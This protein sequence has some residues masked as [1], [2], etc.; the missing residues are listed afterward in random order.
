MPEL[1]RAGP[2]PGGAVTTTGAGRSPVPPAPVP[3]SLWQ[4]ATP[5]LTV[6]AGT[7]CG[8]PDRRHRFGR[9][10]GGL[11]GV[12]R[13]L[14][15]QRP[16]S[17]VAD[18]GPVVLGP[19]ATLEEALD[20][21]LHRPEHRRHDDLVLRDA[22]DGAGG[23]RGLPAT[24]VL[25]A[26]AT[27]MAW[28]ATHDGLTGLVDRA[29]FF[30]HLQQVTAHHGTRGTAAAQGGRLTA[31]E[32]PAPRL[33]ILLLDVDHLKA[34]N[35]SLGH[36]AGDALLRSV[37]TRLHHAGRP[38]D[39]VARLGG[40]EFAVACLLQEP[41]E[42]SAARALGAVAAR[43]LDAV[44]ADDP[45]LDP[46]A[47]ST[48][49][50][51]AA[52]SAPLDQPVGVDALLRA[53]GLAKDVAGQAGGDRVHTTPAVTGGRGAH[54]GSGS[55]RRPSRLSLRRALQDGELLL[56][57]QPI[58]DARTR[59][60]LSVEALV[61]W[62][63]PGAGPLGAGQVLSAAAREGLQR[64][65]DQ[66]V[67]S[68]ALTQ[69][70]RWRRQAHAPQPPRSGREGAR[71]PGSGLPVRVN[72]NTSAVSLA[73]PTFADDVLAALERHDHHPRDLRLE[74]P[75]TAS[76][77]AVQRAAPQ[78]ERLAHAGVALVI[79]DMGT[80]ASSLRHLSAFPVDGIK[81]DRSFITGMLT[82][83]SDHAV[84]QV[85]TDLAAGLG[86]VVT[87]EGVETPEQ[88]AE[89]RRLGV[90]ALQG[91]HLARPAPAELLFRHLRAEATCT[92]AP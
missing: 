15:G 42:Q 29:A 58:V 76:L 40:G 3:P 11:L 63:H 92:A 80:A 71:A 43:H 20:V 2:P 53:A 26:A 66:W 23:W 51:G 8:R 1:E 21:L 39:V 89:L 67:L 50:I 13:V 10:L 83:D 81:I 44:R 32:P 41:D 84:V 86:L 77:G 46:R 22:A 45:A 61:R 31:G 49:S 14:L 85:L 78:L 54:H 62:D 69:L 88:E 82:R 9:A 47:A 36:D 59:R 91:Y 28:H 57:Y 37:A 74:L 64:E 35:D 60:R 90:T 70:T 52:L 33:G 30:R 55:A 68:A 6:P 38:R 27:R 34:V 75:E 4:L 25:E 48:A 56:H 73:G 12:G 79:D 87:A 72:V 5:A 18:P 19:D 24:V 7:T 16:S 65:L 17:R